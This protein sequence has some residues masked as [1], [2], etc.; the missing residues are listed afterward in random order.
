M[1]LRGDL[2]I[3]PVTEGNIIYSPLRRGVF[4]ASDNASQVAIK[5]LNDGK[6]DPSSDDKVQK[7]LCALSEAKLGFQ[8]GMKY[9]QRIAS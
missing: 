2:F 3:I 1:E 7:Y 6:L 9:H 4:W 8:L 5:F